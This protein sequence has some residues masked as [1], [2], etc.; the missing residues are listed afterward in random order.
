MGQNEP[1]EKLILVGESFSPWTKKARWALEQC[2]L[3]YNYEEYTP[4][5]SEPQLRW[6]LKQWTGNVSVPVLIVEKH[7]LRGSW[8][9][10]CY[11]NSVSDN[12]LGSMEEALEWDK[13]SEAALAEGRTRVVRSV[14]KD[15]VALAEA[16]PI[17]IP[18]PFRKALVF[19]A[20]D[21]ATRL[22]KKYSHLYHQGSIQEALTACR[23]A[24]SKSSTGY[25]TQEFSYADITMAA[26]LEVIAPIAETTPTLGKATEKCW[27][28]TALTEKFADLV[29]WRNKLAKNPDTSYSQFEYYQS[30]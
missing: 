26:V 24:L 11:A 15:K 20:R 13:L 18:Q 5:L 17:F 21:A 6:R 4:T 7:V 16:L 12:R 19:L 27:N 3:N 1:K 8:E 23:D 28:D 22:D 30:K 9:I 10:A 14:L 25:I 2:G 29:E